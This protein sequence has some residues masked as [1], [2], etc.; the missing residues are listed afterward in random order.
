MQLPFALI[1]ML[2]VKVLAALGRNGLMSTYTTV[3]VC[4]QCTLA[5]GLGIRYGAMGIAW[6]ATLVSALLAAV[7]YLTARI[8]L[9]RLSN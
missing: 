5:Y 1:A 7:S 8:N 6:A 9:H 3:A 4:L 2:G